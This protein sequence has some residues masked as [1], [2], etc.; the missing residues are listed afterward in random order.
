MNKSQIRHALYRM[1]NGKP[2]EDKQFVY[3]KIQTL[4]AP[5]Q[6]WNDFAVK[7]D[8]MLGDND[9]VIISPET[10]YNF[11]HDTCLEKSF[12]VRS[13]I[14]FNGTPR[15]MN[16]IQIVEL[17]ML[18]KMDWNSYNKTWGVYVDQELKRIHTKLFKTVINKVTDEMIKNSAKSDGAAMTATPSLDVI[19]MSAPVPM[20]EQE[21]KKFKKKK[22]G[23]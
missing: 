17:S 9:I 8:I 22:K 7:W 1:K 16:V 23:V 18:D 5:D 3:D 19:E 13:G 20:T 12:S 2:C 11:I 10:D 6:T 4:L 15:Q 21:I 14:D